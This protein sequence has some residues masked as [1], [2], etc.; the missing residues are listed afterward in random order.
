M[1]TIELSDLHQ[2]ILQALKDTAVYVLE[3]FENFSYDAVQYKSENDP[4]THVDVNTEKKLKAVL[5]PL[6]PGAGFTNEEG[7]DEASQNEWIWIIDPID[8]T[9]NFTHG[10]PYFS[11][12]IALEKAGEVVMGYVY[13]PYYDHLFH[14]IKGQGAYLDGKEI[15]SSANESLDKGLV[16]T[17][18][19]YANFAWREAYLELVLEM[20]VAAH[21]IR[22]L[23][24][25]ALD[26]AYVAT[27]RLDAFFEFDLKPWDVAAGS[28]II[29]EAG[30]KVT[31][32]QGG[33]NYIYGRNIVASNGKVHPALLEIIQKYAPQAKS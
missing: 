9:A 21:G 25:A 33:N 4:F 16:A 30:G 1:D 28:L 18:F 14:A 2:P 12:V 17:G 20:K 6:I 8:G 13:Q 19:P 11:M 27:G 31:D 3:E 10:I 22:R 15:R 5:K 24:S 29:T 26:L 32:F 23:G 7:D